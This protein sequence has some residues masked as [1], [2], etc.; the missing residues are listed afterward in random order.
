MSQEHDA[1]PPQRMLQMIT[2]YWVSQIVGAV[3]SLGVVDHM[4]RGTG[5]AEGLARAS[6]ADPGAM[7][8]LLRAGASLGLFERGDDGA[9]RATA[10]GETLA[11]GPGTMRGMA[12]A[13]T[14]PGHWLP[15]GR[16]TDAVRSGARQTPSTLG[17][18]IFE[19]YGAHPDEGE[20]F[21]QA[22]DGLSAMVAREVAE[23]LDTARA[24]RVVDV[25]GA[26]GTLVAAL[27]SK[28]SA[29]SGVLLELSHVVAGA[30]AALAAASLA[31]RCEV[32]GGDFFEGIPEGDLLLLK[33]VLHDWD[34]ARCRTILSNCAKAMRP[35]G[36]V[37]IVEQIV[38]DDG[39]LSPA[40]LMDLN[41]LVMLRGRERTL[42]EYEA[43]LTEA[44]LRVQRVLQ[45]RSPFSLIEAGRA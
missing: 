34:D 2:G 10:L 41:M 3:A 9:Y 20:A 40:T 13:Q 4:T 22:M 38:P 30:T 12:I 6:G 32:V 11:S 21:A 45:T 26:K 35:G 16:F 25:G 23:N 43:L 33:Q 5:D 28:N 31:P 37:V 19:Y 14:A 36:R 42:R 24:A 44:G 18:E 8:R 39:R 7:A 29:L 15:W 27:L 17:C 1:P